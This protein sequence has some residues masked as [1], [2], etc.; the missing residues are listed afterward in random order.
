MSEVPADAPVAS[1]GAQATVDEIRIAR[2]ILW[3]LTLGLFPQ[4]RTVDVQAQ[5]QLQRTPASPPRLIQTSWR[6]EAFMGW[7]AVP[8]GSDGYDWAVLVPPPA[9]LIDHDRAMVRVAILEALEQP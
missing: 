1:C 7:L 5:L 8:L 2:G 3:A 6:L 4:H 9:A